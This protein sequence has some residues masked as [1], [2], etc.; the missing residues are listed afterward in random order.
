LTRLSIPLADAS[1]LWSEARRT[2]ALRLGLAAALVVAAAAVVVLAHGP[3]T[4]SS[5]FVAPG[6]NTIVVL[7]V[8]G[9]VEIEKLKLAHNALER[10]GRSPA[11]V[12]LVVVSSYAYEALPPGSPASALLPIARL[13]DARRTGPPGSGQF[14][15]P[16]NPWKQSFS[17]GTELSS[18]LALA[19]SLIEKNH[20]ERP[21]VVLISDLLDGTDD[22]ASVA[23]EGV[24]YRRYAI[25]LRIV[26]LAPAVGDLE[27]FLKAVGP[28]TKALQPKLPKQAHVG[29]GTRA[30]F[31]IGLALVAIA[32]A[33]LLA[34]DEFLC[35]P[36][37]FGP[38]RLPPEIEA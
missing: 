36:L 18:G 6:S 31:P 14:V 11:K 17:A 24:A 30:S 7:D 10:L 3:R 37:R 2:R 9:S 20:V 19:R 4:S 16:P 29:A 22:L 33:L 1:S 23:T 13:F 8:S 32:I 35:A 38:S 12:G 26:G 21:G 28:Q 5:P 15:L 27:Y 34:A 25:P